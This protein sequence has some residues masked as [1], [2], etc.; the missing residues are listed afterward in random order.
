MKKSVREEVKL[1]GFKIN[2][3]KFLF[4]DT[5]CLT[6]FITIILIMKTRK[7]KQFTSLWQSCIGTIQCGTGNKFPFKPAGP[8]IITGG[9]TISESTGEGVV[10]KLVAH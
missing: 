7:L 2:A 9:L 3:I 1:R 4:P 5:I 6:L 10:G 8:E